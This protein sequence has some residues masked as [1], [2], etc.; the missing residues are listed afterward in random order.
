[1]GTYCFCDKD[2]WG[3]DFVPRSFTGCPSDPEGLWNA[4]LWPSPFGGECTLHCFLN[5]S[6]VDGGDRDWWYRYVSSG[7]APGQCLDSAYTRRGGDG[8]NETNIPGQFNSRLFVA[9]LGVDV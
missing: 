6:E 9:E 1:M 4:K 8:G 7:Q 3:V 5:E 2:D